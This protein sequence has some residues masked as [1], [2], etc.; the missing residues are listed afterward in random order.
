MSTPDEAEYALDN[1]AAYT[2]QLVR[3]INSE[4]CQR[5]GGRRKDG[6]SP[7]Y[8]LRKIHYCGVLEI[9]RHLTGQHGKSQWGIIPLFKQGIATSF[10]Y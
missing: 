5:Q 8:I 9:R 7:E 4:H 3:S 10:E 1:L 6:Y 2:V